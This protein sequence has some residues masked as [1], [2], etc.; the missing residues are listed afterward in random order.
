MKPNAAL[1]LRPC[2]DCNKSHTISRQYNDWLLD[3]GPPTLPG[4]P[5]IP[6]GLLQHLWVK[7][8]PFMKRFNC[9]NRGTTVF[10]N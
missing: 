3:P 9:V 2:P 8:S 10:S 7:L 6:L 4:G 5:F 1:T